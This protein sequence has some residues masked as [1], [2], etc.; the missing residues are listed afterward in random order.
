MAM[1]DWSEPIFHDN[2]VTPMNIIRKPD[3]IELPN[4][5]EDI[6][7]SNKEGI[8]M[9]LF[10][11]GETVIVTYTATDESGNNSTCKLDI[12]VQ[13]IRHINNDSCSYISKIN[14]KIYYDIIVNIFILR[15]LLPI[16]VGS[17]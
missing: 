6:G 4:G 11:I 15:A 12:T 17:N 16:T 2:S 14:Q 10:P 9:G 13:G 3:L 7:G 8:G 5:I 1:I